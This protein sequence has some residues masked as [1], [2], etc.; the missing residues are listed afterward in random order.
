MATDAPYPAS[1]ERKWAYSFFDFLT[2]L[3][4]CLMGWCC[5][6]ILFGRTQ[7]RLDDPSLTNYSPVNDRCLIWLG[8]NCFGAGFLI[9]AKKRNDL[10]Q[11]YGITE[12]HLE[13][14]LGMEPGDM[15]NK[16][17]VEGAM[18][19]DCLGALCCPVCGLIQAEKEVVKVQ[20]EG[21]QPSEGTPYQRPPGMHY[22]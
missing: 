14:A 1:P 18:V 16:H 12:T 7:A 6:C 2:P 10:R 4:T 20:R 5:P 17:G 8:M 13:S 11:R 22:P 21:G 19:E 15:K 3:D 9:Q